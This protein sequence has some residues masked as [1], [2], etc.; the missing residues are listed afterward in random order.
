[1]R[2]TDGIAVGATRDG[3]RPD[4]ARR[5]RDRRDGDRTT[6]A[7]SASSCA[8]PCRWRSRGS[9]SRSSCAR[10]GRPRSGRWW[11]R[12]RS[13]CRPGWSSARCI[14]GQVGRR[15]DVGVLRCGARVHAA[16]PRGGARARAVPRPRVGH[17]VSAPRARRAGPGRGAELVAAGGPRR[18]PGGAVSA[19]DRPRLGRRRD[20]RRRVRGALD[21][22]RP[23]DRGRRACGS[24]C[25]SRT[26]WAAARA[27]ATAG[28]C[29]PPGT[30][31]RRS[32]GC[33]ARRRACG[34]RRRRPTRSGGSAAFAAEHGIDVRVPPRGRDVGGRR[35]RGSA[36]ASTTSPCSSG[37]A[38][39]TACGGS[40]P[41]RRRSVADSP[42]FLG[43]TFTPDCAICQPAALARGLRRVLLERGVHIFERTPVACRRAVA[44]GDRAHRRRRRAGRPGGVH[45]GRVGDGLAR[46]PA[47]LRRD[48]RLRRG[49][50]A[51]AGAAR[52]H[53]VDVIG[54]ARPTDASGSITCDRPTTAGS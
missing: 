41:R 1:M 6:R 7:S 14:A 5:V 38:S 44:P 24:R 17:A 30:T 51:D 19:A 50:R 10:T 16:V 40:T 9:R 4:R 23:H 11:R 21:R 45:R 39:R 33:S 31:C 46:V 48:L 36:R 42:R 18:R 47:Q 35:R 13:R 49:H 3:D 20:R 52:R 37:S 25:S 34:T 43:G 29:P 32:S 2:W 28:S 8:T 53:R 12:G 27:A 26:S 15:G 22:R 54:R